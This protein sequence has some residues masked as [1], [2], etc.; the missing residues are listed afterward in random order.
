[1]KLDKKLDQAGT[2]PFEGVQG[3][4]EVPAGCHMIMGWHHPTNQ[5]GKAS[6]ILYV[7]DSSLGVLTPSGA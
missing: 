2:K 6:V 7:G 4:I 1:M 3:T 5:S